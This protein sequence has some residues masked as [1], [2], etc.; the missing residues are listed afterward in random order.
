MPSRLCRPEGLMSVDLK[1]YLPL[2]DRSNRYD[3]SFGF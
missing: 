3:G 2:L 1:V